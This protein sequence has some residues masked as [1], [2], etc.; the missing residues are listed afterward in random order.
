MRII[1][2]NDDESSA[3]T[4]LFRTLLKAPLSESPK[5]E[6]SRFFSADYDK[7]IFLII[8]EKEGRIL[9]SL[10][11]RIEANVIFKTTNS[12]S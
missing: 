6:G 8:D 10:L 5:T 11:T 1:T 4:Y 2:L 3:L 12:E 9:G 7:D